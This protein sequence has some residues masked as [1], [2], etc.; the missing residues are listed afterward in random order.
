MN[1]FSSKERRQVI[2]WEMEIAL[3]ALTVR[4]TREKV[5]DPHIKAIKPVV[6]KGNQQAS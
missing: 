1:T 4:T 3:I 5:R 2:V 6:I